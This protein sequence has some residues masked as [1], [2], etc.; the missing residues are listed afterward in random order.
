MAVLAH[1]RPL[2]TTH[3]A[4]PAPE[5]KHG[6]NVWLVAP[7]DAAALTEAVKE[8][9]AAPQLRTTLAYNAHTLADSFTWDK[10]ATQTI[11]FFT[12]LPK[13]R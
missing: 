2:I 3:P 8:L 5:F 7:D 6:E 11:S 13:N 12:S 4:H 1:G 9:A 10:I